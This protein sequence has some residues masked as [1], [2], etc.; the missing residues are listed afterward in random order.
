MA[1]ELTPKDKSSLSQV[2]SQSNLQSGKKK[3]TQ[4]SGKKEKPKNEVSYDDN[5]KNNQNLIK[6]QTNYLKH[7]RDQKK[8]N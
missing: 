5:C 8:K 6:E 2:I 7:L 1:M 4:A 3:K